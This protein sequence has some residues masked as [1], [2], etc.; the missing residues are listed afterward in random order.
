MSD[1]HISIGR[2]LRQLFRDI[3]KEFGGIV[4]IANKQPLIAFNVRHELVAPAASVAAEGK[5][6]FKASMM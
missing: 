5:A 6:H 2:Q 4:D 3:V 1:D